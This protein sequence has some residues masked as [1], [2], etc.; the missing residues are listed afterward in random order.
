MPAYYNELMNFYG[1]SSLSTNFM[2]TL[3]WLLFI[4]FKI[5]PLSRNV[6]DKGRYTPKDFN[7]ISQLFPIQMFHGPLRQSLYHCVIS[8]NPFSKLKLVFDG[9]AKLLFSST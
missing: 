5:R 1:S 7:L 3:Q 9:E 4:N 6:G 8:P 2:Q